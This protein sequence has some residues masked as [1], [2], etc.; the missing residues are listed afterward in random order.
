MGN[1]FVC[2]LSIMGQKKLC[3]LIQN[4]LKTLILL[5]ILMGI[6][7]YTLTHLHKDFPSS[8]SWWR[9]SGFDPWVGK[10][11]WRRDRQCTPIFFPGESHG[12]RSLAGYSPWGRKESDTTEWLTHAHTHMYTYTYVH[13][14]AHLHMYMSIQSTTKTSSA[15]SFSPLPSNSPPEVTTMLTVFDFI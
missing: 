3:Q 13:I 5:Y 15:G 12:Q 7:I 8:N 9:R 10:I 11:L 1:P 6:H 2:L 4:H 14:H